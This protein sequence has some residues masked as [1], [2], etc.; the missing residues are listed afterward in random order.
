MYGRHFAIASRLSIAAA[1][2]VFGSSGYWIDALSG[3][4]VFP[5][6]PRPAGTCPGDLINATD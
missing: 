5:A 4:I 1:P 6:F 2:S 3:Q